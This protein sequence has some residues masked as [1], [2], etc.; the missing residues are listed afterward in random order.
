VALPRDHNEKAPG[1]HGRRRVF[2]LEYWVCG[3]HDPRRDAARSVGTGQGTGHSAR[4]RLEAFEFGRTGLFFARAP[5]AP[6]FLDGRLDPGPGVGQRRQREG[7]EKPFRKKLSP[8]FASPGPL[9]VC[10]KSSLTP[11]NNGLATVGETSERLVLA[12]CGCCSPD[13]ISWYAGCHETDIRYDHVCVRN[14]FAL[15]ESMRRTIAPGGDPTAAD[16]SGLCLIAIWSARAVKPTTS[17]LL[18][19]WYRSAGTGRRTDSGDRA[20]HSNP[21]PEEGSRW[22]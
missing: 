16:Q 8:R 10:G 13:G 18:P 22:P 11:S 15:R 19:L 21:H 2:I 12:R 4:N 3:S 20:W 1:Y 7:W 9:P 5:N 17:W 6:Y 14:G